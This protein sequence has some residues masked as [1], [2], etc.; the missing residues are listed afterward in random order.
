MNSFIHIYSSFILIKTIEFILF[1]ISISIYN[2]VIYSTSLNEIY[3]LKI[4]K[5]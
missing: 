2:K 1:H 4:I 5:L 3:K